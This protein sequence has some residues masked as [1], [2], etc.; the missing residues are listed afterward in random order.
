M[1]VSN[2]CNLALFV[3]TTILDTLFRANVDIIHQDAFHTNTETPNN[4][5][6]MFTEQFLIRSSHVFSPNRQIKSETQFRGRMKLCGTRR[7]G[8]F[9]T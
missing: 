4:K 2:N 3:R 9:A 7:E 1:L 6:F 5:Q 8:D